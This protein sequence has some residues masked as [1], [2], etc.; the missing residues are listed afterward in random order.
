MNELAEKQ[1]TISAHLYRMNSGEIHNFVVLELTKEKT[2]CWFPNEYIHFNLFP[3]L[4]SRPYSIKFQTV[5]EVGRRS[6]KFGDKTK[7]GRIKTFFSDFIACN[8]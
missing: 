4:L 2:I 3:H 8:V 7:N 1:Q 6:F 5:L